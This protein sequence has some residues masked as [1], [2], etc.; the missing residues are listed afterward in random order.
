MLKLESG[1][2]YFTDDNGK[3]ICTGSQMGR[4]NVLPENTQ[5][6]I[7]LRLTKLR[8]VDGDYDE[9]GAYWGHGVG[10]TDVFCAWNEDG[11]RVFTRGWHRESAKQGV[12][13]VL[14]KATFF[15]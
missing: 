11:V 2:D 13:K 12:W 8:W 15:R 10:D 5:A 1:I 6:L 7:K 3:R 9:K 14:P 4:P